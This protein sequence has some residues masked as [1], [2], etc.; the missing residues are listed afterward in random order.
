MTSGE[1]VHFSS[2][3]KGSSNPYLESQI[4][5][6][7]WK[8]IDL[9][10]AK[11]QKEENYLNSKGDKYNATVGLRNNT[12]LPKLTD[13]W[14]KDVCEREVKLTDKKEKL[15]Q[16]VKDVNA[17]TD[18][19]N[20]NSTFGIEQKRIYNLDLYDGYDNKLTAKPYE[21]NFQ[22]P[23]PHAH[24][25]IWDRPFQSFRPLNMWQP[26]TPSFISTS[27]YVDNPL[28]STYTSS[29]AR[30]FSS[31]TIFSRTLASRERERERERA[32]AAN[33]PLSDNEWSSTLASR[34]LTA[35]PL[36]NVGSPLRHTTVRV[37]P[38]NQ[39][40]TTKKLMNV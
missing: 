26:R 30:P 24:V 23:W 14:S 3:D 2:N 1:F 6:A 40:N 28:Q 12:I 5:D 34:G 20:K 15:L 19:F 10:R 31:T 4:I 38:L 7:E 32:T 39:K 33:A 22:P 17:L 16:D 9:E 29:Y 8:R 13:T 25:N 35:S 27:H 36:L 11:I 37:A 21:R 18:H